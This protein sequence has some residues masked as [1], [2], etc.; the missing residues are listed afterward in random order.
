MLLYFKPKKEKKNGELLRGKTRRNGV[1]S[2]LT[3]GMGDE[4]ACGAV[5]GQQYK[6]LEQVRMQTNINKQLMPQNR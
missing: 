3:E 2:E 4:T 1:V 6:V 5:Y